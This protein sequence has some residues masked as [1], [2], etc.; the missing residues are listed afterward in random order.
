VRAACT[1]VAMASTA[2]A[3]PIQ[4]HGDDGAWAWAIAR[5]GVSVNLGFSLD[6]AVNSVSPNIRGVRTRYYLTRF[7]TFGNLVTAVRDGSH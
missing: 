1:D 7:S 5:I 4:I 6:N 3:S 2:K